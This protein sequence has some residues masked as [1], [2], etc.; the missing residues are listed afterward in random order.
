[1]DN[2]FVA[3]VKAHNDLAQVAAEYGV[4]LKPVGHRLKAL[5]PLHRDSAPS[6]YIQPQQQF[7]KC[8]GCGASGDVLSLVMAMEKLEFSQ[9]LERLA[10]RANLPMPQTDDTAWREKKQARDTTLALNKLAA[11]HFYQTLYA[12]EG[13]RG[14]EYLRKRGI[15]DAQIR[16]FGIGYAGA[17]WEDLLHAAA[18][19]S[20]SADAVVAAGLAQRNKSG[21]AYDLFRE[22]VMFPIIDE[23]GQCVGFG[24]RVLDDSQPK[25]LN[26]PQTALFEK[27]RLLFGLNRALKMPGLDE[28]ILVEG[29]MDVIALH[30]HG[31]TNAVATLGTAFTADHLRVIRRFVSKVVLC[32]DSDGA[33]VKA[34]LRSFEIFRNSGIAVRAL[35]PTGGKDPDEVIQ[36]KGTAFFAKALAGAQSMPDFTMALARDAQDMTTTQG[37]AGFAMDCAA[38]LSGI[39]SPIEREEHLGRWLRQ[40]QAETGVSGQS[41]YEEIALQLKKQ[42]VS[43]PP[44]P[45]RETLPD[46]PVS[47]T[48][49][50]AERSLLAILYEGG[51]ADFMNRLEIDDFTHTTTRML[52]AAWA[53]QAGDAAAVALSDWPEALRR[54]AMDILITEVPGDRTAL[55]ADFAKTLQSGRRQRVRQTLTAQLQQPEL[56]PEQRR[57]LLQ[58][59]AQLDRNENP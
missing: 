14:L 42:R 38:I 17:G 32:Y 52:F 21:K 46:P 25:Y 36:N 47:T 33:G 39:D 55:L 1:M 9:A 37:R 29:Y 57:A 4:V 30:G 18:Q 22:R 23:R 31:F 53:E 44:A 19:Q 41:I 6:F 51:H 50:S 8:F 28:L 24:G 45:R 3:K 26:S 48:V 5:C 56:P 12:P 10:E 16:R 34:A 13:A 7:Y 58:Q 20:F 54:E 11:H 15:S 59:V 40:L 49:P 43:P 2:D 27:H 35:R